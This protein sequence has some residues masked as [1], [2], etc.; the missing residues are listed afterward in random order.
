[1]E[2]LDLGFDLDLGDIGFDAGEIDFS[3]FDVSAA[4]ETGVQSRYVKPAYDRPIND[5]FVMAENADE[6]ARSIQLQRGM[7]IH[8][9]ISGNFIFSHFIR[10]V[11]MENDLKVKRLVISTLSMSQDCVDALRDLCDLGY[12]ER[13]DLIVSAYFFAH[14]RH[15]S[16]LIPYIYEELDFDDSPAQFQLAVAGTHCKTVQIETEHG[17][18]LVIHGSANPRSSRSLE[19]ICIE[20]NVDLHD[21]HNGYSDRILEVYSTVRR[22]VRAGKLWRLIN[23]R[24]QP[25]Q[26]HK[27][28]SQKGDQQD[29]EGDG[30]G[31]TCQDEAAGTER[32]EQGFPAILTGNV[33]PVRT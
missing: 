8:A 13:L 14:E 5:K 17:A 24:R 28:N 6:F 16:G 22:E 4:I 18:K 29:Q 9:V 11:I 3:S 27:V 15:P 23:E 31:K 32:E 20:E 12:V 10:A 1:M 21:F 26:G 30:K 33:L 19:Q 7:R 25:K 2:S